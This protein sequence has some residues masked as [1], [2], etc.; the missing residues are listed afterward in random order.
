MQLL[1]GFNGGGINTIDEFI[2]GRGGI[3]KKNPDFIPPVAPSPTRR[4]PEIVAAREKQRL[5]EQRRKG[6]RS[7]ILTSGRGVEDKLGVTRPQA[8][9]GA[10][11]LGG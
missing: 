1:P 8:R 5:T 7:T 6:R 2:P 9:G 10:E 11:L 4:D 3:R